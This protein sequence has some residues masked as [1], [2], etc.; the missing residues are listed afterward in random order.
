MAPHS[1]KRWGL[2]GVQVGLMAAFTLFAAFPF[3]W[4]LVTAFK[5]TPD[6][7]NRQSNPFVFNLPP[8]LEHIRILFDDT[9]YGRWLFNTAL[10]G[11]LVVGITLFLAL[12][13]GYALARLTGRAGERLGIAIFLTYLVPP[14]LLFIPLSRVVVALGLQDSLWSLVVVYPSFT[15]PFSTWLLMGFFKAIPRDLEEA[16]MIDG[17]SRFGA[18]V[19]VVV[20]ISVAGILT[21]VIFTFTLVTQEFV[22]ALTFISPAS[23]YTVSVGVPTFLVHGDV[24]FWGSLMAGC[25]IASVPI[26]IVYNFFV[27]RFIAG[28]TVGAVK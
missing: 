25:F 4:M 26:A 8:T 22:Y 18:F 6:L 27:D 13:A 7:M 21:V 16:A 5:Q 19:R 9:L 17:L 15:V 24:Y 14:T 2:G 10:V 3:Y 20:P 1:L 28:F 23:Q 11:V 12:P